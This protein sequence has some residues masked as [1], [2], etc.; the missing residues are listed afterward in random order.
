MMDGN[1]KDSHLELFLTGND[2][3]EKSGKM[4]LGTLLHGRSCQETSRRGS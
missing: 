4:V 3:Y 2:H 1:L